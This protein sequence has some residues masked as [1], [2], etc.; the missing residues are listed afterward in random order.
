MGGLAGESMHFHSLIFATCQYL[1]PSYIF[2][3]ISELVTYK[4]ET[5]PI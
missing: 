4:D 2:D 5:K 1:K 3:H